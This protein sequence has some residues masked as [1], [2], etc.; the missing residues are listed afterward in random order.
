MPVYMYVR[1]KP[2]LL[3]YS[4]TKILFSSG[5]Q[6]YA[7]SQGLFVPYI[8]K[9]YVTYMRG[10]TFAP[11][12]VGT[13]PLCIKVRSSSPSCSCIIPPKLCVLN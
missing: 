13:C 1:L 11:L 5:M 10:W 8:K 12:N 3:L 2:F 6:T 9:S 7:S 4:L